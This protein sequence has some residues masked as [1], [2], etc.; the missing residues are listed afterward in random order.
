MIIFGTRSMNST[1]GDGAFHCPRC[2]ANRAYRLIGVRRWFTLYFIPVIPLGYDGRYIE[3][4]SCAGTY[5]EEVLS[6]D[7]AASRAETLDSI[8]RVFI[9]AMLGAGRF[10]EE[11]IYALRQIYEEISET[12]IT[13]QQIYIEFD[14]AKQSGVEP[15]TYIQNQAAD[16]T[17]D[18]KGFIIHSLARI[19]SPESPAMADRMELE[20][21]SDAIG[22]PAT[23]FDSLMNEL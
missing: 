16:L 21:I 18:G 12:T 22:Y 9:M 2:N 19:F 6:Y 15:M 3:C 14:Q 7:P 17:T 4:S 13:E 8:R 20:Q 5:A 11:N 23:Q 10:T 1:M